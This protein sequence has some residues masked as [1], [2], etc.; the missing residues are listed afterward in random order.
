ML[1]IEKSKSHKGKCTPN[2][3]PCR[4]NHNGPVDASRRYW[5]PTKT[6]DGK[7]VAYFRGRKL[8]GKQMMVPKGYR[9]AVVST[10]DRVLPKSKPAVDDDEVEEVEE[11]VDVKIMEEQSDFDHIMLWGHEAL[12]DDVTDP[13]VRGIEEWI[14]LSEQI[15]SISDEN[16]ESKD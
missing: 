1:T 6:P 14:A 7:T 12:P 8:H 4:I 3:L 10:T 9:G 2:V 15:H 11:E 13:Y 16:P 5:N